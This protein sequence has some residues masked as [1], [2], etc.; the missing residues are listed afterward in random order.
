M[1]A[2]RE[3]RAYRRS[4]KKCTRGEARSRLLE[5]LIAKKT[6]L[7]EVEEFVIKERKTFHEV[8]E[9]KCGSKIQKYKE[10]RQIVVQIMRRKLKG[11]NQHCIKLRRERCINDKELMRSLGGKTRVYK[12]IVKDTKK[13]CNTLRE[14]L[15]RR[16]VKKIEWLV[17]KY[18]MKYEMSVDMT[19]DEREKYGMSRILNMECDVTAE[20]LREPDIV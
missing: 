8:G 19:E 2:S 6:G 9:E 11:N 20:N 4:N 13:N 12:G 17:K 5:E 15:E 14:E 10:E 3:E 16:N 7:R 18:E 1:T